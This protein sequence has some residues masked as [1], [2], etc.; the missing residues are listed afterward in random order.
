MGRGDRAGIGDLMRRCD[1]VN[2][3]DIMGRSDFMGRSDRTGPCDPG[4]FACDA[5][6][7]VSSDRRAPRRGGRA[8]A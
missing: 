6:R 3:A 4:M 8:V 7:A 1:L 5:A 2:F